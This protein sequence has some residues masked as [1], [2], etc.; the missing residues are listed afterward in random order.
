MEKPSTSDDMDTISRFKKFGRIRFSKNAERT[1]F[2]FLTLAMLLMGLL[3]KIG[4]W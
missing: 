1:L 4:I 3:A 2:F